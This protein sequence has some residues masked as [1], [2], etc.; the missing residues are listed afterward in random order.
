VY[1]QVARALWSR[2]CQSCSG[3]IG[4]G[5]LVGRL[6]GIWDCTWGKSC[7]P[8]DTVHPPLSPFSILWVWPCWWK[9]IRARFCPVS[10]VSTLESGLRRLFAR[11]LVWFFWGGMGYLVL[12]LEDGS[13][14]L[15][16]C[17]GIFVP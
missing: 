17:A 13:P 12:V 3:N 14:Y 7:C 6:L 5:S 2:Y 8:A 9:W 4:I 15:V 16:F 10:L 1:S 11:S